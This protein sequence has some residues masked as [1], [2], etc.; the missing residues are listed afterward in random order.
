MKFIN[1]NQEYLLEWEDE[2]VKEMI[3]NFENQITYL[4]PNTNNQQNKTRCLSDNPA[5]VSEGN[6]KPSPT[7]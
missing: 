2:I 1:I 4:S 6:V 7:H 3:L 5:G